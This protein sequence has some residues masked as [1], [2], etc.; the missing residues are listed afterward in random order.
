MTEKVTIT[1]ELTLKSEAADAFCAG[2]PDAIK[3]TAAFPGFGSI[4]IVR[5]QNRVL[6]IETWDSE[7]AYDAYIAWRSST[8]M[9]DAMAGLLAAPP[10]KGVWP[11]LVAGA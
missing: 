6:F 1:L 3:E 10:Q 9:M 4:R 11:T 5:D 2:L 8:G 7:A